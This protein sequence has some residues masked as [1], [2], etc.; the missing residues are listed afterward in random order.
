MLKFGDD[1]LQHLQ[2]GFLQTIGLQT[3]VILVSIS[4][5]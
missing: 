5:M 1:N 2:F 3:K 4:I